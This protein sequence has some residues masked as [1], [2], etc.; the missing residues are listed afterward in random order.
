MGLKLARGKKAARLLRDVDFRRKWERLYDACPWGTVFQEQ[1]YLE[2]WYR[3]YG[4]AFELILIYQEDSS[5]E[6]AGLFPLARC[7]DSDKLCFA[8]DY[9]AEYK[10]W[11]ATPANGNSFPEKA[12]D[13]VS[14]EFPDAIL[15]LLFLAP[16]TPLEWTS[17]KWT[18]QIRLQH[19]PRPLVDLGKQNRSDRSLRKRGNKTRIRQLK[20][21]GQFEFSEISSPDGFSKIFDEI[22]NNSHLRLSGLHNVRPK[23]DPNRKQ[24]HLDLMTDTDVVY[25]T[26]LKV[27]ENI[28]SS[29]VC[30][31]NKDEMLLCITSMSPFFAKQSPSKIHL[32]MLGKK[33]TASQFRNFDLSPGNGYK[34]RFAT[35]IENS[36][37]LTVF[38]R[39]RDCDRYRIKRHLIGVARKSL[40]S[41]SIRKTRVFKL[42]DRL[43]HKL[44]RSSISSLP[45]TIVKNLRRKIYDCRECRMY[46]FDVTRLHSFNDP[47]AMKVD[48]VSDLLKYRPVSGWQETTSQFHK[49]VL[50]N[51]ENGLHSYTY[52]ENGQLLHYGWLIERQEVSKIFEVGQE[53]KLPP[54]T[55]VLFDYYTH[56]DAR[57]RGLY[58]KSLIQGLHDASRIPGTSQVF[59]GVMADNVAS[60]HVIEKLGFRY[61]GSLFKE[62]RFGRV[63]KW[64]DW[65]K[66][67]RVIKQSAIIDEAYAT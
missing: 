21:K 17:G 2:I 23:R 11:L 67:S 22:E 51:F 29:Q 41:L 15:Q 60:R 44:R 46:S 65:E 38:F 55:S 45:N 7:L 56:P 34:E 49:K 1:K 10:T 8:G 63:R 18:K 66:R 61:E 28:A 19:V 25:P 24:F 3:N 4:H 27:G 32:L 5:G 16:N 30:F 26:V 36:H 35:H 20:K 33:L 53:F 58:Q 43:N 39:K 40:E 37:S 47:T 62:T 64:Q 12:L 14:R 6:L 42:A 13:T 48:S 52:S 50:K 57:G 59:I 31:R 9:H 54:N